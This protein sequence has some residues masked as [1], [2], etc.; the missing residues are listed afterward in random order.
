M[1]LLGFLRWQ[2]SG[3]YKNAQFWSCAILLL[4]LIAALGGC[5]GPIPLYILMAGIGISFVDI[6]VMVV[7][8][9]YKLYKLEQKNIVQALGQKNGN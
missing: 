8:T 6:M 9:Q 3:F 5:P 7:S 2:L 1:Q 4:A